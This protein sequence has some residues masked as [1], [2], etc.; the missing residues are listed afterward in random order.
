MILADFINYISIQSQYRPHCGLSAIWLFSVIILNLN[1]QL[2]QTHHLDRVFFAE[3]PFKEWIWSACGSVCAS[4]CWIQLIQ[5]SKPSPALKS[6]AFQSNRAIF[7]KT[8]ENETPT[9][10][11]VK[12]RFCAKCSSKTLFRNL[13]FLF[14]T[15]RDFIYGFWNERKPCTRK[16]RKCFCAEQ[17]A[18]PRNCGLRN[19][20]LSKMAFRRSLCVRGND[21]F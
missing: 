5:A 4:P 20:V 3:Q 19:I 15:V 18:P 2:P 1:H 12:G 9:N 14:V 16:S 17:E 13:H 11:F 7:D 21:I 6:D 8:C 10:V